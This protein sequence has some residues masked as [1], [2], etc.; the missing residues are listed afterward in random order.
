MTQQQEQELALLNEVEG[1]R[2]DILREQLKNEQLTGM[3]R[4]AEGESEF[5]RK[6][7]E[8]MIEKQEALQELMAK[9]AKSL[10]LT[11]GQLAKTEGEIRLLG[12]ER[13]A[14]DRAAAKVATDVRALEEEMLEALNQQTTA[15]KSSQ[16]AAHDIR[17]MRRR[18]RDEELAVAE[19]QNEVARLQV[20]VAN[21]EAANDRLG[22]A[23]ALVEQELRENEKTIERFEL[24]IRRRHD[25]I[26]R[27]TAS[28]DL[29]NKELE[30]L[31]AASKSDA[32]TGPLEATINNL[33]KEIDAKGAEGRELQRRWIGHQTELV[34]LSNENAAATEALA[35]LRAEQ[36]ILSQ[37]RRRLEA[38]YERVQADVKRLGANMARLHRD[39]QRING[40]ISTNADL[41]A[42]LTEDNFSLEQRVQSELRDMEEESAAMSTAIDE[43]RAAKRDLLAEIVEVEKQAMLWERKIAL[44]REMQ[45]TLNPEEG[46]DVIGAMR[47]EIQRME[48]RLGELKRLQ[49]RLMGELERAVSKRA[50]IG[51]K[52][53]VQQQRRNAPGREG[54]VQKETNQLAANLRDAERQMAAAGESIAALGGR[55]AELAAAAVAA[56]GACQLL[57]Q[58][59]EA[60]KVALD[61]R[62]HD[63]YRALL[64]TARTQRAARRLED[65]EAGRYAP[66]LDSAEA[67]EAE[68]AR[69]EQRQERI[70]ALLGQL[71][72]SA[73]AL[74]SDFDRV[75]CHVTAA[76]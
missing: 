3:L 68:L 4:K 41:R 46:S 69:A 14:V 2:K 21:T 73:P 9:L 12:K 28:M 61:A 65:L 20:D 54:A 26:E 1:Y 17:E 39:I 62:A 34:A 37:K 43:Q 23:L 57:R 56:D 42:A 19:T 70:A 75:L 31:A 72:E 38:T 45:A 59:E 27:K 13:E 8:A 7:V 32:N 74:A 53:E 22:D 76:Q 48:A 36:T 49:E 18:V 11:E 44:E 67:A 24:E 33:Q 47:K 58:Q 40:L 15:E 5:L 25:D 30:R 51:V 63:K 60:L 55:K 64:A 52:A 35:R 6:R 29:L 16:K 71:K 66:G 50:L 10:E